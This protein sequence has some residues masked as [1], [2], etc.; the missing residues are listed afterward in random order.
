MRIVAV[1]NA[2]RYSIFSQLLLVASEKLDSNHA[3]P[4][5]HKLTVN[6]YII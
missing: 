6:V 1:I 5:R 2:T 4:W 3:C